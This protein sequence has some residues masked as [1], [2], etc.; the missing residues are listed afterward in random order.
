VRERSNRGNDNNALARSEKT[1]QFLHDDTFAFPYGGV[2][3]PVV[4][5]A[6]VVG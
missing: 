1:K 3:V 2:F 5:V 6:V 4:V